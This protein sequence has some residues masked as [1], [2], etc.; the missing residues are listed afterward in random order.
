MRFHRLKRSLFRHTHQRRSAIVRRQRREVEV[1]FP[2]FAE[3]IAERHLP[4]EAEMAAFERAHDAQQATTRARRAA[5]WRAARARLM[6]FPCDLRA[7]IVHYWNTRSRYPGHPEY[8]HILISRFE[9]G[10]LKITQ[11]RQ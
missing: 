10:R 3:E 7:Q 11:S 1:D 8:L 5:V 4:V 2:L 9:Q 6:D